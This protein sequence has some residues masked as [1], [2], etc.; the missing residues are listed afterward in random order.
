MYAR[1][2]GPTERCCVTSQGHPRTVFRRAIERR[3]LVVAEIEAREVGQLDLREA[4]ELTALIAMHDRERGQR[5]A[6]RWLQRW[7]DE[8]SAPTIDETVMIAG[9]LVALGGRRHEHALAALRPMSC[10]IPRLPS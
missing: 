6:V 8:A 7:L 4:L 1:S 5:Y 2:S 9:N 10:P 3:N